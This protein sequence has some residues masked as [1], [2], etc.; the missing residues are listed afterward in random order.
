MTEMRHNRIA[1]ARDK[2]GLTQQQAADL[3]GVSVQGYQYYEYGKR[4]PKA[5]V[6]RRL[7]EIFGVSAAYLLGMTSS[8]GVVLPRPVD[9][10]RVPIVGRIAAGTP[11]EAFAQSDEYQD[12]PCSL[13]EGREGCF[14]LSV[15]GNSMNRLFP[16][17]SLVLVDQGL[18]VRDGDVGAVFVNGYDATLKRV[19]FTRDG[20][21]LHPESYDPEYR[22]MFIRRDDPEAPEFR[23]I[24]RVVS[25]T[26]PAGWRA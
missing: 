10:V 16:E 12:T 6:I 13:V 4:D 1:E 21:R 15:A 19:F 9:T 26:A 22:D 3:L 20:I 2:A 7:C 11:R 5:S 14:W 8:D 24:G 25:Y 23:A 17:G 18:E